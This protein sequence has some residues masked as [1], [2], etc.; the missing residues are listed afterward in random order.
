[1]RTLLAFFSI[2]SLA[3]MDCRPTCT[4]PVYVPGLVITVLDAQTNQPVTDATVALTGNGQPEVLTGSGGQFSG[5]DS[6]TFT[7]TVEAA[8]FQTQTFE[9]VVVELSADGC[10]PVTEYLEVRLTPTSS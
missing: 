6:G 8:G 1:M 5:G 9:N 2:S 7:I 4:L 3:A 10:G